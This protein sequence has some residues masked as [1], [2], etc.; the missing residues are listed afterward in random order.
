MI[1]GNYCNV[2]FNLIIALIEDNWI[3]TH[4][5]ETNRS[6][7]VR[8]DQY[9]LLKSGLRLP[10]TLDLTNYSSFSEDTSSNKRYPNSAHMAPI[11]NRKITLKFSNNE[12][13]S[14]NNPPTM[15]E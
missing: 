2:K 5:I 11:K 9:Q 3:S 4:S 15:Y 7:I 1:S 8:I 6:R 10:S 13:V 14:S 12:N